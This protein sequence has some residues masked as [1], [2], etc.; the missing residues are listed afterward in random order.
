MARD[1]MQRSADIRGKAFED[2]HSTG[3]RRSVRPSQVPRLVG[4]GAQRVTTR[5]PY[6]ARHMLVGELLLGVGIVGIRLV[7]DYEPQSDG[8]MKGKI[9]HPK[10][11]YGPFPIL[12][13][14]LIT[15]FLLSFLAARGGTKAKVAVIG[16]G[17]VVLVLGMKSLDEFEKTSSTFSK[18]GKANVAPGDWATSGEAAGSPISGGDTGDSGDSGGGSKQHPDGGYYV[19]PLTGTIQRQTNSVAGAALKLAGWKGP[20]TT[21]A[22]AQAYAKQAANPKAP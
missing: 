9:G 12:T 5:K 1:E 21:Y 15:F 4:R 3:G 8:T 16:G 17:L 13:G 10:G 11:Q 14:L 19:F 18:F 6:G 7:A 22:E 2:T 20:F